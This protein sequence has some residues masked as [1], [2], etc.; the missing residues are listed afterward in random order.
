[1]LWRQLA[2]IA[3]SHPAEPAVDLA[4]SCLGSCHRVDRVWIVRYNEPLTHFWNTHE[5]TR[6]GVSQH[7]EDLQ[8]ASVDMIRWMQKPLMA[9]KIVPNPDTELLPRQARAYQAELRR[10]RI[11]SSIN[12]PLHHEGRLRGIF[13]YDMVRRKVAWSASMQACL[14]DAAAYVAALLYSRGGDVPAPASQP[15]PRVLHIRSGGIVVSVERDD[16]VLIE[17]DG[18][19][20]HLH[21]ASRPRFTELR[22]LKSWES[23]L[24]EEEF[25]RISQRHL[26]RRARIRRLDRSAA[27]GWRLHLHDWS[28]PLAVGRTYRHRVRQHLGF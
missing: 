12:V 15:S 11:R 24:P 6:D 5:W 19:Y 8:A 16:L 17:A 10:Q 9:G 26:I 18:D 2:L 20:T 4:L 23:Q 28:L 13:G 7:V 27:D 1:M 3:A 21:F 22:S 14:T 25:L